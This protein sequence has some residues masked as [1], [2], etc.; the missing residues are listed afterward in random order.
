MG[1]VETYLFAIALDF[2]QISRCGT[3][4]KSLCFLSRMYVCVYVFLVCVLCLCLCVFVFLCVYVRMY[5]RMCVCMYV[6]SQ[7]VGALCTHTIRLQMEECDK[8]TSVAS[9]QMDPRTLVQNM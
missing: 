6:S 4:L 8:L 3:G 1:K 5:V 7:K 2:L 9:L